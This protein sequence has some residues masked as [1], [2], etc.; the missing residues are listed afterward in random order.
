M[1]STFVEGREIIDAIMVASEVVGDWK[2]RKNKC[3]LIKLDLEKAYDKVD[4]NYLDA[5]LE[6]KGF[7]KRWRTWSKGCLQ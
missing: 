2:E 3:F 5:I 6:Y 7:G 4:W 1:M